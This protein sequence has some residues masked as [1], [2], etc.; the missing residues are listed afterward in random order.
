M[1]TVWQCLVLIP[2]GCRRDNVLAKC[3]ADALHFYGSKG[4]KTSR[5]TSC[6][7][8]F[9]SG[10]QDVSH[11]WP[12]VIIWMVQPSVFITGILLWVAAN[13][14]IF[15][16]IGDCFTNLRIFV[17]HL[18]WPLNCNID[19]W[20]TIF[21]VLLGNL[22]CWSASQKN[23]LWYWSASLW[24]DICIGPL[25]M[26]NELVRASSSFGLKPLL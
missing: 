17:L 20:G 22:N 26:G 7:L 5:A 18:C 8:Y 24:Y 12:V 14:G 16:I 9:T 4:Q 3:I 19:G 10:P 25:Q 23:V 15:F 1:N 2:H 6:L 13:V 21:I 11:E